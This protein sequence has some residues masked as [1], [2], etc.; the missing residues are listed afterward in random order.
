MPQRKNLRAT[1][2]AATGTHTP[3]NRR[4]TPTAPS[5]AT[6]ALWATSAP[7]TITTV[8]A[9]RNG[10]RVPLHKPQV[11]RNPWAPTMPSAKVRNHAAN[12][13]IA[14]VS[15]ASRAVGSAMPRGGAVCNVCWQQA[16]V[17]GNCGCA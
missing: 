14:G 9:P 1:A 8:P 15:P 10:A 11:V 12:M 2:P 17:M 3:G 6:R 16:S 13:Q 4:S 7:R 5:A